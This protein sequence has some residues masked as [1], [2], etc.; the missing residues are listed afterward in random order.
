MVSLTLF[1]VL[2]EK[3]SVLSMMFVVGFSYMAFHV[4]FLSL[5]FLFFIITGC[6]VLSNPFSPSVEMIISIFPLFC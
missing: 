3:L 6:S 4:E 2:E 1:Q 5:A